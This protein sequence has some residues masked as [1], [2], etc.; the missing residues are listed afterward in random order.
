M[1]NETFIN[2]Y[3]KPY[4]EAYKLLKLV[5]NADQ[6]SESDDIWHKYMEGINNMG[7]LYPDNKFVDKLITFL[8]DA[9]D[10]IAK[11][12]RKENR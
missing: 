8:L 6:T 5:Q 4:N 2:R 7:N 9:G 11:E 12:N 3:F 10:V 1:D